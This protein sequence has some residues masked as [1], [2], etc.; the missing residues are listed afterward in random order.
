[1]FTGDRMRGQIEGRVLNFDILSNPPNPTL[2][3]PKVTAFVGRLLSKVG[4]VAGAIF[5]MSGTY[6]FATIDKKDT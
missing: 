6:S 3:V 1:M 5:K 2:S 4:S